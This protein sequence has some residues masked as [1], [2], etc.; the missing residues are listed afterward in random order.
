[1]APTER[2]KRALQS[3]LVE[4]EIGVR[5]GTFLFRDDNGVGRVMVSAEVDADPAG[6]KAAF[7]IRDP[8][9][10]PE[11][12]GEL[13]TDALVAGKDAPPLVLFVAQVPAGDH[14]VKLAIVDAEGRVGSAVRT[15]SVSSGVPDAL[16]LGDVIVLPEGQ[17]PDRA[18]PSARVAQGSRQAAVYFELYGG[19]KAPGKAAVHLEVTDTPE[20]PAIVSSE[21]TIALKAKAK[22][23]RS[24]GQLKFS[25]AA[26]PPG[27][28][29]ARVKVEG[30]EARA[31][32]GFTVTAGTS[33]AL[34]SDESRALVPFFNVQR[35]LNTP[36]LHAVSAR[37]LQDAAD[38]AAV[39]GVATA[40]EDGSWRE[41]STVTGNRVVDSTLKGLQSLAAGQPADA[42][43]LFRDALDADPEFTI[44]LTLVG[45]A[46][47]SVGREPEASRSWRTSL[48]TGV[49]APFLY[50]FVAESLLRMGDVKGTRDFVAEVQEAG[51]D[52]STLERPRALASAIAGDRRETVAALGRWVDAHPDDQDAAFVLVLALYELKTIDKDASMLPEFQR[53]AKEY[54]DRGGPRQALVARWMK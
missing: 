19:A 26:L 51:G 50:P 35:F 11:T 52:V 32:R 5:L 33:A 49:D 12:A 21:G 27:R 39:N 6:L 18:R 54:I 31:L 38:N 15:I 36:L 29:F 30:S 37:F 47:A 41:L 53:R 8:R 44:A 20:G 42:E 10:K 45:G 46:W 25:P 22:I 17:V 43:R 24:A 14:T 4:R 2:L 13:A 40:L 28:Y 3:P 1:L 7:V 16:V 48:A 34:L 23:A 9:G